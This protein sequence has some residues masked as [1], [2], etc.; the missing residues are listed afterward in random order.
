MTNWTP[1]ISHSYAEQLVK[2]VGTELGR[3]HFKSG[4]HQ[5]VVH[6]GGRQIGSHAQLTSSYQSSAL[7]CEEISGLSGLSGISGISG[8]SGLSHSHILIQ[9]L[10][11]SW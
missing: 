6:L 11:T 3:H 5:Q 10:S 8:I 4:C 2:L 9:F 1:G 7:H